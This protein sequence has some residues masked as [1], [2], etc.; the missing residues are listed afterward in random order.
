MPHIE[1]CTHVTV[2]LHVS[3]VLL[4]L[5]LPLINSVRGRWPERLVQPDDLPP[6][7][8]AT[9]LWIGL[10]VAIVT[11]SV[12]AWLETRRRSDA[13][14]RRV[15]GGVARP[16]VE[17]A[18][19]HSSCDEEPH[20]NAAP[21]QRA[22]AVGRQRRRTAAHRA[23]T[24]RDHQERPAALRRNSSA[25]AAAAGK[26]HHQRRHSL[27]RRWSTALKTFAWP[28]EAADA[29]PVHPS[30]QFHQQLCYAMRNALVEWTV[31]VMWSAGCYGC[32][33]WD[34][35]FDLTEWFRLVKLWPMAQL[36]MGMAVFVAWAEAERRAQLKLCEDD[37]GRMVDG[38]MRHWGPAQRVF[39]WHWALN[40]A[41]MVVFFFSKRL[42]MV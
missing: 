19:H 14:V 15:L 35:S 42:F 30:Q 27:L 24:L 33:M 1:F 6:D 28:E 41:W 31:T 4:K 40:L 34:R 21:A 10:H 39:A 25:A 36:S 20:G 9:I 5:L 26:R 2:Y 37:G 16:P 12:Y 29:Q 7:W 13:D 32:P 18:P 38:V 17:D 23:V 3:A 11:L 22:V 8:L